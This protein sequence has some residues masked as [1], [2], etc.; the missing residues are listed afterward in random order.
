MIKAT[1]RFIL[2]LLGLCSTGFQLENLVFG[3]MVKSSLNKQSEWSYYA[4]EF[5]P[6]LFTIVICFW[7][8]MHQIKL[9]MRENKQNAKK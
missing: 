7:F 5:I 6:H 1:Y 8:I 9:L 4:Y 2:I 3:T